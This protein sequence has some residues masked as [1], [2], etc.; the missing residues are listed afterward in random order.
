M[1]L[2]NKL[3]E[4]KIT[5]GSWLTIGDC[6][7][8]EIMAR[9][10]FDWLAVDME[11][12]AITL[13]EAQ[14][15]IRTVELSGIAPLVRVS[16]NNAICIK[17]VMDAGAHGVI[18][19]M[20]NTEE[21]AAR[22]VNAVRYPPLGKRGVGLA[23]A[24]R[25]GLDFAG[26]RKWV[27]KNSV[28]IVQIEHIDAVENLDGILSTEGVDGFIIGPYDLSASLGRPGDFKHPDVVKAMKKIKKISN[29]Y[30]VSP[31]F[32]VIP[33]DHTEIL[34]KIG[35]GFKFIGFSLD[36]LFLG[37]NCSREVNELKVKYGKQK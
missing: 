27:S 26:Y 28:T 7:V 8:A 12:S 19:P 5:I 10:G 23:R 14:Q 9:A 4:K 1:G 35:E 6:S 24:Q 11:H 22:A 36:S 37:V 16:E 30:A 29:K 21:D 13:S 25:Y 18:V 15:L 2:K 3:K 32:H 34:K 20:V 17:R 33:P 31:G